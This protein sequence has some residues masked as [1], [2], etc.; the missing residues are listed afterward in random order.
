MGAKAFK[1]KFTGAKLISTF[2]QHL[3]CTYCVPGSV[4]RAGDLT[5][6]RYVRSPYSGKGVGQGAEHLPML[7]SD[8]GNVK[9]G[10]RV[11]VGMTERV[12]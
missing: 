9:I 6:M 10:Q 12:S 8:M 11:R 2:H 4:Y 7:T 5:G 3:L 1:F